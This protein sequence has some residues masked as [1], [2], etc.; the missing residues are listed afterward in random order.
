MR[1]QMIVDTR[2]DQW[3]LVTVLLRSSRDRIVCRFQLLYS[4]TERTIV[5]PST[6]FTSAPPSNF[7]MRIGQFTIYIYIYIYMEMCPQCIG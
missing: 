1:Y 4:Y 2:Q 5:H 6:T 3:I 7:H